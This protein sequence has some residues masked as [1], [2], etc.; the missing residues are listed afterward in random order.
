MITCH[1]PLGFQ[2]HFQ[3]ELKDR[4]HI[5]SEYNK[6]LRLFWVTIT[7]DSERFQQVDPT[8]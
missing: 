4:R 5:K 7:K 2:S 1:M 6:K 8:S 3:D